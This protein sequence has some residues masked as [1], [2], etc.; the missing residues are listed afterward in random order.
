[1]SIFLLDEVDNYSNKKGQR[2]EKYFWNEKE[3][4]L[5]L[6]NAALKKS[7]RLNLLY[8]ILIQVPNIV[9]LNCINFNRST[10]FLYREEQ[11]KTVLDFIL[12]EGWRTTAN[13]ATMESLME[14][15]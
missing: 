4:L 10:K 2:I 6:E 15:S 9:D 7:E 5:E 8:G 3:N 1:M 14:T 11:N 12:S 13:T